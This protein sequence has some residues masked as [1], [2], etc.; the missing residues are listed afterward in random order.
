M[1]T[2]FGVD[3]S[4]I[5]TAWYACSRNL[6]FS[7][8]RVLTLVGMDVKQLGQADLVTVGVGGRPFGGGDKG[9]CLP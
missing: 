7:F 5:G 8:M 4:I 1:H 6:L 2:C 3:L 9:R